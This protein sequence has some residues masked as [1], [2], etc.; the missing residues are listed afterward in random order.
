[1]LCIGLADK[2]AKAV[3]FYNCCGP[4]EVSSI[5]ISESDNLDFPKI[6]IVNTMQLH[7]LGDTM[8]IGKPTPNNSVYVLGDD[9]QPLPIGHT[10]LMWAG[11]AGVTKGNH[12][13]NV[14]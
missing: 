4:T 11:G 8:S 6:T 12:P 14:L 10:G 1:M 13:S 9:L 3:Q 5:Q 2:W 7:C